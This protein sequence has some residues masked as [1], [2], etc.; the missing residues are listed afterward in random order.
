MT[1]LP[2]P[3][4][5][6]F[7][8][9]STLSSIEGIDELAALKHVRAQITELTNQAMNGYV[10]LE[11]V[12]SKRLDII[13]PQQSDLHIIAQQYLDT[14]TAGALQTVQALQASGIRTAIIS[15][16]LR[17]AILPLAAK[18]GIAP[19]DVFA[20]ELEFN[21]Q[22][23]YER[24]LPSPLATTNGKRETTAAWKR[25]NG[26]NTVYLI[27]D[28]MSD[29]AAKGAGAADAVIGYGGIVIRDAVREA[30]DCFL[31][32]SNLTALLN[33]WKA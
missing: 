3:D 27:G 33:L 13:R 22:G 4:G 15:G 17:S 6:I 2:R 21:N 25:A 12:Y 28:G 11:M 14:I 29:V 7:D 16:G 19:E 23:E 31:T 8:C 30:A 24:V 26:L 18:L 20:V 10:P 9:D 1:I 32:D 5:I